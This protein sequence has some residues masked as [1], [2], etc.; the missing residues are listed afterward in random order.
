MPILLRAGG[1][2]GFAR[3]APGAP[4]TAGTVFRMLGSVVL[5]YMSIGVRFT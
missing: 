5:L 4:T 1:L 3:F 2:S